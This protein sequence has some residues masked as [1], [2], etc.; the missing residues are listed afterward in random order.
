MNKPTVGEYL[1]GK[2]KLR[3][4]E[5]QEIAR[6]S[7][8]LRAALTEKEKEAAE[9]SRRLAAYEHPSVHAIEALLNHQPVENAVTHAIGC[10][11]KWKL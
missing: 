7:R 8:A 5:N 3:F 2:A 11:I 6:S 10:T 9:L 1:D 4:A